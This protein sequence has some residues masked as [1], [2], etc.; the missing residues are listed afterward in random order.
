MPF[1]SSRSPITT[2]PTL[3]P[4]SSASSLLA[5]RAHH[6]VD[7]GLQLARQLDDAARL[8]SVGRGH[9]HQP[10]VFDAGGG[11][12]AGTAASPTMVGTPA[13]CACASIR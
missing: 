1:A 13:A 6:H 5:V 9:H 11:E 3:S 10:R 12:H 4:S 8:E 2:W 7:A